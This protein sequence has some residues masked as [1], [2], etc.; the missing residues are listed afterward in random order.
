[1]TDPR[2]PGTFQLIHGNALNMREVASESATLV[3][4]SPPFF[5]K[6]IEADLR[7]PLS[8]QSDFD[9]VR[10]ETTRFSLKLR[11]AF[12]EILR[13][14]KPGGH[15]VLETKDLR[16]GAHLIP[17]ASLHTTMADAAGFR[18]ATRVLWQNTNESPR[19]GTLRRSVERLKAKQVFR[20]LDVEDF[21]VFVRPG[22][23]EATGNPE[24]WGGEDLERIVSPL[25]DLPG[26]RSW[27]P[28]PSPSAVIRRFVLVLSRE[29]DLV[30]D[31]FAGSGKVLRVAAALGRNAVGY[32]L[33]HDFWRR[34]TEDEE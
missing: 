23:R 14:L 18:L 12:D 19:H 4:T 32:E 22:G 27:H 2:K 33:D 17:L 8:K 31:P 28:Y 13:V 6:S 25:W 26:S 3:L 7:A 20:T 24:E 21:L 34:A 30:V 15:L 1:M 9:S 16:F 29:G 11:P 5:P 10:A